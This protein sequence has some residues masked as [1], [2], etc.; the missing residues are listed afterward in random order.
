[1]SAELEP[2]LKGK[3]IRLRKLE[4]RD[5]TER[6]VAWLNDPEV[7]EHLFAGRRP[8]TMNSLNE[9][10]E[11]NSANPN[12]VMFAILDG[13]SG[14]HI[15]NVKLD[16][17]DDWSRVVDFGLMIGEKRFWGHGIAQEAARLTTAWAFERWNAHKITLGVS[18]GNPAAAK[19]CENAGFKI[20]G[21]QRS[22]IRERGGYADKIVMGM[23]LEDLPA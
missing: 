4:R 20:E 13:E 18:S 12:V 1:M 9:Y 6:Y 15:G 23:L 10:F 14:I 11:S 16:M 7:N 5:L 22:Q 17:Y 2:L 8:A 19:F 21:R 3:L